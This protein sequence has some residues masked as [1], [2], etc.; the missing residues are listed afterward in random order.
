MGQAAPRLRMTPEEYLTFERASETRHEYADGEIFAMSGGTYEHSLLAGAIARELG[1]ALAERPCDVYGS[2]MRIKVAA[3]RRFFYAD[4]LVICGEPVFADEKR[5]TIEN[6]KVIIEVL[7]DSTERYDRGEKFAHYRR[8]DS[9]L[10]YLLVSQTQPL[11][12][13][14]SR[15]GQGQWLFSAAGPGEEV[16]L[17]SIDC[18]LSV[19]RLYAK[20]FRPAARNGG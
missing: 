19:D 1:N 9:L 14:F 12:D 11:I 10:D 16:P 7:S 8:L 18:R 6:P 4:V 3:T 2:D 17:A 20:L 15:R 5:D 13:H